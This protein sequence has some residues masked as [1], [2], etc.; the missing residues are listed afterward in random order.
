MG[1]GKKIDIPNSIINIIMIL[2]CIVTLYPFIYTLSYSF[3]DGHAVLS[4]PITLLP[5]KPTLDNYRA[6][7]GN[8]KIAK[9]FVVSVLRTVIG[10]TYT[11]MVT[12]TAAYTL[13]KRFLPGNRFLSYFFVLPM[14]VGGGMIATFVN[15]AQLGLMNKFLVYILPY[16][17]FAYYM[18]IMRTYYAG[19]PDSLEES[20]QLD[21]ASD[22]R[23][24]FSIIVPLSAPIFATIALFAGVLQ[25]NMWF[26]AM[27]YVPNTSLHPLQL[28][29]QN[30]LKQASGL[31]NMKLLAQAAEIKVTAEAVQMATLIIATVPI[32]AI[33]P[34]VQRYFVKGIMIGSVKA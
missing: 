14:Y 34:F 33:Y 24:F 19:I 29:L 26:D 9:A 10:L 23:I 28:V 11:L 8:D 6:V 17:F 2:L 18:L 4:N 3:S 25:W 15:I 13:S 32:L 7:F 12:G 31:A 20:A 1:K 30:V 16:G 22:I 21:G 5:V 27:V